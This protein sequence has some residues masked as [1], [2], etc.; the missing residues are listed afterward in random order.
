MTCEDYEDEVTGD[1]HCACGQTHAFLDTVQGTPLIECPLCPDD[2]WYHLLDTRYVVTN[3][4]R[5]FTGHDGLLWVRH[6]R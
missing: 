2:G 6:A 3:G 1:V 5:S 4:R